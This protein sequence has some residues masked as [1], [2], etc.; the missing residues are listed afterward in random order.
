MPKIG[1]RPTGRTAMGRRTGQLAWFLLMLGAAGGCV[2]SS[3]SSP[4]SG[5]LASLER[6]L[7]FHPAPYPQG[8]WQPADLVHEDAWFQSED[9]TRLHGWF[10]P[11]QNPRAV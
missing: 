7:V 5:P 4:P 9:G 8:E 2:W 1:A 6:S 11:A 3:S 10:C